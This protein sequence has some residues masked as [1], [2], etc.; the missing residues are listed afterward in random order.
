MQNVILHLDMNSYFASCEQQDNR[1][2]RGKPVGVCEHLGGIIIGASIEAKTWGIT[3][4]TPVWEAKRLYPKIILTST[5]PDR[6]RFYTRKLMRLVSDYTDKVEVSSIDEVFL[7]ITTSCN[8]KF[9]IVNFPFSF[10]FQN[11]NFQNQ[12]QEIIKFISARKNDWRDA[13]P[14]EE[15]VKLAKDIKKRIRHEIGDWFS[16]SIG[17][18][19]NKLLAKIGANLQK[20]DGLVVITADQNSKSEIQHLGILSF[21]KNELY[22]QLK[23]TD[24]PGIGLR[25]EQKLNELGIKTL[26]DLRSYPESRLIT[27]FGITGHHLHSLGQLEG[28][29]H[30]EVAQDEDIKSL[31]HMYTLP[32]EFRR[33]KYFIPV[34]YKLSEMVG[35]RLRRQ[36]L[37]GNILYFHLHD[38]AG[39]CFGKSKKFSF[40]L[41]DGREIFL[42]S[43]LIFKD[44]QLPDKSF[45]LVGVTVAGL[46]PKVRQLSLFGQ[47][48]KNERLLK[49]LDAVNL[50]YGA[51]KLCRAA[52]LGAE[53]VFR[54]SVGFGRIKEIR[55]LG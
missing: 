5:H 31:G 12:K 55:E 6:Y 10:D 40:F 16:C 14:W 38:S 50:K 22:G 20:P 54:D 41:W 3:T 48:E 17:I 36:K 39:R 27:K 9:P 52:M 42:Q 21:V 37:M 49:A 28:S 8:V 19:E 30:P 53:P 4:G 24:V 25:M 43:M 47:E 7:D 44:W 51:F 23:L 13:N 29:F 35:Q 26:S 33:T 15:A 34:L 46:R 32:V 11:S 2:W 1:A 18:A 45:K